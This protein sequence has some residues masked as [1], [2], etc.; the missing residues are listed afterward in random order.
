MNPVRFSECLDRDYRS[1]RAVVDRTDPSTPVPTCPGWTLK[2]LGRHVAMVYLHKVE[3]IRSGR[4]PT[5]WPPASVATDPLLGLLDRSYASL[6]AEFSARNPDDPAFTWYD[7]DQSVGFWIRRMAQETLIHRIDA[8]LSADESVGPIDRDLAEDGIDELLVAFVGFGMAGWPEAFSE[9]LG[10]T[11]HL[12]ISVRTPGRSWAADW[13][14]VQPQV[15]EPADG[16]AAVTI[17]GQADQVVRW[18][19]NRGGTVSAGGGAADVERLQRILSIS[20]Q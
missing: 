16:D 12:R 15:S 18:L 19:W 5:P 14:V 17:E 9:A 10:P 13:N 6:I 7:P 2:E 20:T 11:D 1:L 8:E 4:E 3:C